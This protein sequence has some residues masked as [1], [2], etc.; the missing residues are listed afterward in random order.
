MG[1]M[2][3]G[4]G[5]G[6]GGYG[7]G[8]GGMGGG[9]MGGMGGMGGMMGGMGGM[10]GGGG[11]MGRYMAQSLRQLIQES[12]E[13]D[14]WFELSDL[15]EGTIMTYPTTQPKKLAVYQTAEVHQQIADLLDQLRKA[16]GEQ[17][18]IEARYL[19][20]SE[21]FLEDIGLDLDFS[22][23]IGG[24]WG[25]MT[26]SQGS[27]VVA[28]PTIGTGVAG[29]MGNITTE[30]PSMGIIGGYG[31]VLDDLQV[32]FILRATQARSDSKSLAAPRLT[33][34][35]GERA[36]FSLTDMVSYALPP[37][38][39]QG[40]FQTGGGQGTVGQSGTYQNVQYLNIGSM[41]GISPT[42]SKDK[43]YVLL[44][45]QT[46]QTD[47]LGFAT[48]QVAD[49]SGGD[50]TTDGEPNSYPV[51]VPE[52]ET[53]N[54][55]TRVSVPDGGTLLLGGHKI[56]AQ[57]EKEAGVPVLSKI[58][59]IG[60]L[61]TNRSKVRDEKVLLILVKPTIILQ[62][63]KEQEAIAAMEEST[64]DYRLQY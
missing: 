59:I 48:H 18:S 54:V 41:L 55:M 50:G 52:T 5:G 31:S 63:E 6:M 45:I 46:T 16:L 7:G 10:M 58:P 40:T 57:A 23:N 11:M 8:M 36:S 32:S 26:F 12:I 33:V 37:T 27:S 17:V 29:S 43:K 51:Q 42:I 15:G 62:D 56:A 1:G 13:P 19:V 25:L 2:M 4:M 28:A 9:M 20:V 3:G 60:A 53:A 34:M 35:S 22:Y 61:F 38:Q 49:T 44:N 47:L 24:K 64:D 14:S 39:T 30:N 21:N